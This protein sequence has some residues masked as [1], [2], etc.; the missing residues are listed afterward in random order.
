[1]VLFLSMPLVLGSLYSFIIMLVYIPIIAKRIRNEEKVLE[2]S[3]PGY[4]EY[5]QKVKYKVIPF[6]W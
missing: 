2:E 4:K 6:I 3:L 5:K 1:M